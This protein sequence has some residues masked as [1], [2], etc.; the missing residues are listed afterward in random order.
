MI[1][2]D[3]ESDE[4]IEPWSRSRVIALLRRWWQLRDSGCSKWPMERISGVAFLP[5]R[6]LSLTVSMWVE[7]VQY[8]LRLW[9][10]ER[11]WGSEPIVV[12]WLRASDA[13]D[14]TSRK[15]ETYQRLVMMAGT[16]KG[17][18]ERINMRHFWMQAEAASK[19]AH[20]IEHSRNF[21]IFVG[22]LSIALAVC[23]ASDKA[24]RD[25]MDDV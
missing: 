25:L 24:F 16:L 2:P 22:W 20:R 18:I 1:H 17:T 11:E 5:A 8:G 10:P 13:T 9:Y 3:F 12:K 6:E 7:A 15:A 14:E 4:I 19:V 23:G 21:E